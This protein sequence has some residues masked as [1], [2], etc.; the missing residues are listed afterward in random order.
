[1][2]G[3]TSASRSAVGEVIE[4]VFLSFRLVKEGRYRNVPPTSIVCDPVIHARLS[5]NWMFLVSLYCVRDTPVPTSIGVLMTPER[6]IAI[7]P[8]LV[9]V[10]GRSSSSAEKD[11]S[12]LAYRVRLRM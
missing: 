8:T 4:P 3:L 9:F 10:P 5:V 6:A 11:G 1:M 7:G 2:K 12:W